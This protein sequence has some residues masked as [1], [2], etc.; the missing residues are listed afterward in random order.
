MYYLFQY[1][2]QELGPFLLQQ[3]NITNTLYDS[4]SY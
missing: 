4:I 3:Y 1:I 2:Y